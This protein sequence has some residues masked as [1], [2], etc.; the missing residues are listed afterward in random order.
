MD[1]TGN[2]VNLNI[3]IIDRN[4]GSLNRGQKKNTSV[5]HHRG[6]VYSKQKVRMNLQ[7]KF[8]MGN[9]GLSELE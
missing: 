6:K 8:G 2:T 4:V 3:R 9:K 7:R 5:I 1:D